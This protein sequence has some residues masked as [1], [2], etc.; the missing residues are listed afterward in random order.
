VAKCGQMLCDV[1]PHMVVGDGSTC[2]AAVLGLSDSIVALNRR[3]ALVY[4]SLHS[5]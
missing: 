3:F 2:N 4:L 5:P 1:V